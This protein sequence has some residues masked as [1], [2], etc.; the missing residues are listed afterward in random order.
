MTHFLHV[1]DTDFRTCGAC[2]ALYHVGALRP[3]RGRHLDEHPEHRYAPCGHS[4]DWHGWAP[5]YVEPEPPTGLE[6]F[7]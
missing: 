3:G 7:D 4:Q 1:E 5:A 2:G 6:F